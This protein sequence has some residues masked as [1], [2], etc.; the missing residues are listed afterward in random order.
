MSEQ[1]QID[2]YATESTIV[3]R[4]GSR[5]SPSSQGARIIRALADGRWHTTANIHRKAGFS[6]LNSRVSELRSRHGFVIECES[7]PGQTGSLGH[8]Y[9]LLNPPTSSEADKLEPSRFVLPAENVAPR[10]MTNRFRIYRMRY[11]KLDLL[12]TAETPGD[13]GS[14]IVTLGAEGEFT[15]TCFGLL[16]THGTDQADG[17]WLV[18]PWNTGML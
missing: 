3:D 9:R 14:A 18:H 1:T 5:L 12:A 8:R 4:P 10:D 7:V 15:E 6:R 17:T 16:D 2:L 11:D 13:V